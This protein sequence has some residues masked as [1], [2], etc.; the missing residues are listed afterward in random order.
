MSGRILRK[1]GHLYAKLVEAST[2]MKRLSAATMQ[3]HRAPFEIWRNAYVTLRYLSF[4]FTSQ[5]ISLLF[6]R[7]LE[8][9]V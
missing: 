2:P 4:V 8:S 9:I 1:E 7:N 5:R 3:K 6:C